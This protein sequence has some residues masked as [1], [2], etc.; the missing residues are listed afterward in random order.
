MYAPN[1]LDS[2]LHTSAKT[3]LL[4]NYLF[5]FVNYILFIDH[6]ATSSFLCEQIKWGADMLFEFLKSDCGL[7]ETDLQIFSPSF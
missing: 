7:L 1:N 3:N 5:S 2:I 6:V 4:A